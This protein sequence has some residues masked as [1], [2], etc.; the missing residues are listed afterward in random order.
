MAFRDEVFAAMQRLRETGDIL[1]SQVARDF[2]PVP[3]YGEILYH[4]VDSPV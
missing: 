1:E 2:W 4:I 3:S